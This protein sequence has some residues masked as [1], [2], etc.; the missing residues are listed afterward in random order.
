MKIVHDEL[1]RKYPQNQYCLFDVGA[2]IGNYSIDL[3]NLFGSSATIHA[4]E[5]LGSTYKMLIDNI[6]PYSNIIS[7]NVGLSNQ[8]MTMPVY[9]NGAGSGLTSVY[10][11]RLDHLNIDM[12]I[13][14]DCQ[15]DTIDE[16]C[17]RNIIDHVHFMKIDVEGHELSVLQ[18]ANKMIENNKIDFIQFE[19]GGCNIDSRTFFQDFWYFLNGKYTIYRIVSSG[20]Y[21]IK[22]YSELNEIFA[23]TNFL[24][25]LNSK[26]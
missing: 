21:R 22:K 3:I 6:Q 20:L 9:T 2:N 5:P 18:G 1:L 24:A 14:Q 15:F 8:A 17:K 13:K 7:H 19:F 23:Y 25:V 11:R 16:F 4:F 26:E 10:K 12:N